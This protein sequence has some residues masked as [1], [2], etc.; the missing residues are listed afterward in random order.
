M[1]GTPLGT[2]PSM[3][4][5]SAPVTSE[6]DQESQ[7]IGEEN[8]PQQPS[9]QTTA[10]ARSS[11]LEDY[12]VSL[13]QEAE[14]YEVANRQLE[15]ELQSECERLERR[16]ALLEAELADSQVDPLPEGD[17]MLVVSELTA[18]EMA[19]WQVEE[20]VKHLQ[21]A[22]KRNLE[23]L[24]HKKDQLEHENQLLKEAKTLHEALSSR[25]NEEPVSPEVL[26]Q[27]TQARAMH[28]QNQF[29]VLQQGLV[30]YID[31]LAA[32]FPQVDES[33]STNEAD[34]SLRGYFAR[35]SRDPEDTPRQRALR[36]KAVLE[37]L[38][39]E[40]LLGSA[41]QVQ[42]KDDSQA[43]STTDE[44]VLLALERIGMVEKKQGRWKLVNLAGI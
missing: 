20:T 12:A 13:R 39:N 26:V 7:S 17:P 41:G 14:D 11:M 5:S 19:F 3:A 31:H 21:S 38:M 23:E 15:N 40:A 4:L 42:T 18:L 24:E 30:D 22:E 6:V 43:E 9:R 2:T 16:I 32:S 36:L 27:R 37:T 10:D 25:K 29:R 33:D 1:P 34:L 35:S 8:V 44:D 28:L